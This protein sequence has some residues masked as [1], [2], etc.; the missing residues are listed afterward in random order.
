MLKTNN[1]II[2]NQTDQER[3]GLSIKRE[4]EKRGG[5]FVRGVYI[6]HRRVA[7]IVKSGGEWHVHCVD[8]FRGAFLSGIEGR[9]RTVVDY[10]IEA[11]ERAWNNR[12]P[13]RY[14]ELNDSQKAK[15]DVFINALASGRDVV[16]S[17]VGQSLGG[18]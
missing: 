4:T 8:E 5:A 10:A 13:Q 17:D 16:M 1:N 14:A 6:S 11:V 3:H 18:E 9:R 2:T 7:E 15:A 12:T